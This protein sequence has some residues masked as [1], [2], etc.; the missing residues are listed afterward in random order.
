VPEIRKVGEGAKGETSKG[1]GLSLPTFRKIG[2]FLANVLT[3]E[4]SVDAL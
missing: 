2:E 3:L 1:K 4:R